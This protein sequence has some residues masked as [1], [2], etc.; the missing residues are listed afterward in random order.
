MPKKL[1][2]SR[3]SYEVTTNYLSSWSEKII[4][5]AKNKKIVVLDLKGNQA[6]KKRLTQTIDQYKPHL[7]LLNGHGNKEAITGQNDEILIQA[8]ENEN[9]LKG[10]IVYAL[11]CETG[12]VLGPESIKAGTDVYIGYDEVFIFYYTKGKES[13]PLRDKRAALF[14]QPASEVSTSLIEGQSGK[15]AHEK[16]KNAFMLNIRK[17]LSSQAKESYLVRYL[18]WDMKHQV[19]LGNKNATF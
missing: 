11:S 13:Q 17:L 4:N 9:I 8:G 7:V 19:C 6:N 2:L 1:L 14:L 12:K 18:L 15:E 5:I 3:P 10:K 16:S